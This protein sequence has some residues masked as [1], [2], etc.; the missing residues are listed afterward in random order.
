MVQCQGGIALGG[1][2]VHLKMF[3]VRW[4][5][6]LSPAPLPLLYSTSH[7]DAKPEKNKLGHLQL[8]SQGI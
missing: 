8:R 5:L 2:C 4:K 7:A 6:Q 3:A 1:G